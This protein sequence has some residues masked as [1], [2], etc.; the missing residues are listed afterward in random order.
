MASAGGQPERAGTRGQ[1]GQRSG[2]QQ[3]SND[4]A[5]AAGDLGPHDPCL[6]KAAP[7]SMI[8]PVATMATASHGETVFG[9]RFTT[10]S[11]S[12]A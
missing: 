9:Q 4:A 12:S 6:M 1:L 11:L 10:P 3:V 2:A 8:E 5:V 7:L